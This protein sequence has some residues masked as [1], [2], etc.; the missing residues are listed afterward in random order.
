MILFFYVVELLERC[1]AIEILEGSKEGSTNS[2][3]LLFVI[4]RA[5]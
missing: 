5:K 1:F 3:I 2:D 4:T